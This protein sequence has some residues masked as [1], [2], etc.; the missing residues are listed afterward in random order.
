MNNPVSDKKST[1]PL[2]EQADRYLAGGSFL[3]LVNSS[4][5]GVLNKQYWVEYRE[6]DEAE[7]RDY[8][9]DL[10]FRI[11]RNRRESEKSSKR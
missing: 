8:Y 9:N 11:V 1:S 7:A 5:V 4:I 2:V 3:D 10:G 6:R